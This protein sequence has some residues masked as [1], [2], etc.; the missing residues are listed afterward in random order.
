[1]DIKVIVKV[2]ARIQFVVDIDVGTFLPVYLGLNEV[3]KMN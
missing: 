1:M 2:K 3:P